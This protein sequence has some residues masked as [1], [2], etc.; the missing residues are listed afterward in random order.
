MEND[1]QEKVILDNFLNNDTNIV[2]WLFGWGTSQYT[3]HVPRQSVGNALIPLQSGF[4]LTLTDFGILGILLLTMIA[5]II[6]KLLQTS[7][8]GNNSYAIAFSVAS[9]SSFV[10]SL[11]FGSLVTCFIYLMLALYAYYDEHE[12]T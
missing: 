11:I 4:V 3:F 8:R 12:P 5:Y 10:G 1:R 7:L 9:M 2:F 6:I